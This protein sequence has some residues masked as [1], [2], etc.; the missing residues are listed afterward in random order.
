M[1]HLKGATG[2]AG[3]H[4]LRGMLPSLLAI[5]VSVFLPES[6]PAADNAALSPREQLGKHLFFDTRLSVPEGQSCAA[7]HGAEVGFTGPDGEINRAGAVYEGAVKERFGNRKPPASSYGGKSPVLHF[8]RKEKAWVGGMFWDGRATGKRM[9]DPLAE[10]AQGPFLNPLE[11]NL[12]AAFDI[13]FAFNR[14]TLGEEFCTK[15][16]GFTSEQL[17]DVSF[18]MLTALG[19]SRQQ[20]EDANTYCC[21]AMTLEGA[22]HLLAPA[23]AT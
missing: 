21:G 7:C 23:S 9:K 12:A 11:Q 22:P 5:L 1:V 20:I 13:R 18:D 4:A 16:L 17:N 10:Q 19:F 14:W 3:A 2:S 8:D 15:G 6:S